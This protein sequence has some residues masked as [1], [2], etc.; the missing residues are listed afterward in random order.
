MSQVASSRPPS[1]PLNHDKYYPIKDSNPKLLKMM[2]LI[3]QEDRRSSPEWHQLYRSIPLG[4]LP[5]VDEC[6]SL[7]PPLLKVL[8]VIPNREVLHRPDSST[9][10]VQT[11]LTTKESKDHAPVKAPTLRPNSSTLFC[12]KK[13]G[14]NFHCQI[15][16]IVNG[17]Q[18]D[19]DHHPGASHGSNV[20][21][22][23]IL[24]QH[25]GVLE[26]IIYFQTQQR[27]AIGLTEMSNPQSSNILM[28]SKKLNAMTESP[29]PLWNETNQK[30][31][32]DNLL[33]V[34]ALKGMTHS[35]A[36]SQTLK[37]LCYLLNPNF[38]FP[39][40]SVLEDAF[41]KA[42]EEREKKPRK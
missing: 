10:N 7:A 30:V 41:R 33:E 42:A 15:P 23:H 27:T 39:P 8:A 21:R 26:A 34:I 6:K 9:S 29:V 11:V 22:S 5:S 3:E 25:P 4:S 2:K 35:A 18:K 37:D 13:V 31:A 20:R 32:L 17:V 19:C 16:R 28:R 14:G 38:Q 36:T 12:Y 24:A 40:K 1:I